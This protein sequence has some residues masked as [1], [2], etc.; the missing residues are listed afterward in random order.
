M[1]NPPL[2]SPRKMALA[3]DVVDNI[4]KRTR[5]GNVED[6]ERVRLHLLENEIFPLRMTLQ[7]RKYLRV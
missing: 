7:N 2:A 1:H 4:L 6:M 5:Y 3:Q